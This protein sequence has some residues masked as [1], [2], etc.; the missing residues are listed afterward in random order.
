MGLD[1]GFRNQTVSIY[2]NQM[3]PCSLKHRKV[4][5][6]GSPEII[7][8]LPH[9]RNRKLLTPPLNNIAAAGA[10]AIVRDN[11]LSGM[12]SLFIET[13]Q[14]MLQ[15]AGLIKSCNHHHTLQIPTFQ[16]FKYQN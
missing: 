15:D 11:Y 12:N 6:P 1:K 10:R 5:Y 14:N 7:I 9:K 3:V 13:T 2:E 16:G 8:E 4:S